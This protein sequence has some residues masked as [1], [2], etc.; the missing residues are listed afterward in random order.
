[1]RLGIE[2]QEHA[3][4]R[5]TGRTLM[6]LVERDRSLLWQS[7]KWNGYCWT[8]PG[9]RPLLVTWC[10][11]WRFLELAAESGLGVVK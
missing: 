8:V 10:G 7:R 3:P 6:P 9:G 11:R 2:T 5:I 4:A 1:M